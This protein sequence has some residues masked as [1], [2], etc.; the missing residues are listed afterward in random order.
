MFS[1]LLL[2]RAILDQIIYNNAEKITKLLF[3]LNFY[4]WITI[5]NNN[6][7]YYTMTNLRAVNFYFTTTFSEYLL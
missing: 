6:N 4:L 7:Y 3:Q 2:I 5:L 1:F